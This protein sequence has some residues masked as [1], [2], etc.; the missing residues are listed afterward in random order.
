MFFLV[1]TNILLIANIVVLTLAWQRRAL[2]QSSNFCFV[3]L[4]GWIKTAPSQLSH[5]RYDVIVMTWMVLTSDGDHPHPLPHLFSHSKRSVPSGEEKTQKTPQSKGQSPDGHCYPAF[6][7]FLMAL[8]RSGKLLTIASS[9]PD[10]HIH[11]FSA[12]VRLGEPSPLYYIP[13][14]SPYSKEPSVKTG[15]KG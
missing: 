7:I 9:S 8:I 2:G 1:S 12:L 10:D 15:I 3:L 14:P 4:G 13:I 6:K 11:S 5:A